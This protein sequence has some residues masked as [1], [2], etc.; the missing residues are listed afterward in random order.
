MTTM[1]RLW[2]SA[3]CVSAW[4]MLLF[5]GWS[6]GGAVHLLLVAAAVLF[7]WKAAPSGPAG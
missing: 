2:I 5:S 3:L 7:P 1:R 6:F 4:L